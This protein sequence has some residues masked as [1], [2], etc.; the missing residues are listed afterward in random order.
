M[1]VAEP[2]YFAHWIVEN[3]EGWQLPQLDGRLRRHFGRDRIAGLQRPGTDR[4]GGQ[5]HRRQA[6]HQA[7]DWPSQIQLSGESVQLM[8]HPFREG[9]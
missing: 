3:Q 9:S 4:R 7:I 2:G 5:S 1:D 8:A 6:G